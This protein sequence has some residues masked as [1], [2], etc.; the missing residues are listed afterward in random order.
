VVKRP[1]HPDGSCLYELA[2]LSRIADL[3]VARVKAGTRV[4]ALHLEYV[5][6]V[7][8][9][10]AIEAGH[11]SSVLRAMGR[12]LRDIQAVPKSRFGASADWQVFA[13]GDF[14][15][16]NVIVSEDGETVKAIVDW[17]AATLTQPITDLAWCQAQ[18]L[19]LFPRHRYA[20]SH[21]F[22]GY[23]AAP[24]PAAVETVAR[25]YAGNLSEFGVQH[26]TSPTSPFHVAS[27]ADPREGAAFV[28]AVS[29]AAGAPFRAH[30]WDPPAEIWIVPGPN[31]V[32]AMMNEPAAAIAAS[33]FS[34][35]TT[36]IVKVLP[37]HARLAVLTNHIP[38]FGIDDVLAL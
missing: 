3:P 10:E 5:E 16:Y 9:T 6:G 25:E 12:L 20:L 8:A 19:R 31:S 35:T 18:F 33:V 24:D 4:N 1:N 30:P 11:A 14:A 21:L 34:A 17:E 37:L 36:S 22:E 2:V 23:G 32:E 38:P 26:V 28:A 27:F 29:R 13:H 15:P 7:P